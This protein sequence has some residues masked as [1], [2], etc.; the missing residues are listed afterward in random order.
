M[1][2]LVHAKEILKDILET[3]ERNVL[4]TGSE[5][6]RVLP[7]GA[8][9]LLTSPPASLTRFF[10]RSIILNVPSLFH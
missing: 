2:W 8:P 4:H 5:S 9:E 3:L 1:R 7:H 6:A 10:L